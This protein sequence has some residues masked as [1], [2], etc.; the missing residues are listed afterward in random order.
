[1]VVKN[2]MTSDEYI[3]R[4]TKRCSNALKYDSSLNV[5]YYNPWLTPY[6][7]KSAVIIGKDECI[8]DTC[9]WLSDNLCE[10]IKLTQDGNDATYDPKIID[11][12]KKFL[13]DK[14]LMDKI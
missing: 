4:Y 5:L 6:N 10:Y 8:E 7:A 11:D 3:R 2:K 14:I 1:M 12:L 9:E 13:M